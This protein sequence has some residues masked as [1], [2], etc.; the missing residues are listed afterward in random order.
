MSVPDPIAAVVAFLAADADVAALVGTTTIRGA[1]VARV[2]GAAIP[3]EEAAQMPRPAI[4]VSAAGGVAVGGYVR[5]QRPRIDVKCYGRTHHE[6]M[7]V[8]LAAYAA[9]RYLYRRAQGAAFL[10]NAVLVGGPLE[11][12]DPHT[13]WP[14][15]SSTW[16][17]L[18]SDLALS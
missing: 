12:V 18:A 3:A 7:A 14:L 8:H 13:D 9:L 11:L 6:A 5:L 10:H 4:A 17:V 2:F 1:L 15:V 16:N